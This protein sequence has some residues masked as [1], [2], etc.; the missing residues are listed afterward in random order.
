MEAVQYRPISNNTHIALFS[1]AQP[2]KPLY[3]SNDPYLFNVLHSIIVES[4][5]Q[6]KQ[7]KELLKR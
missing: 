6:I 5:F 2:N 1:K 7:Q 3:V 4:K